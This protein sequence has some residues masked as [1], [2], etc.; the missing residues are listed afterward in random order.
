[1]RGRHP[2]TGININ[3]GVS[4]AKARVHQEKKKK[5]PEKKSHLQR[6]TATTGGGKLGGCLQLY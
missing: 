3:D 6:S 1:M 2:S 4:G 5:K